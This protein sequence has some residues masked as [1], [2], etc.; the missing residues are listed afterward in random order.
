MSLITLPPDYG[1]YELNLNSLATASGS[2]NKTPPTLPFS[3]ESSLTNSFA[4]SQPS[5]PQAKKPLPFRQWLRTKVRITDATTASVIL[6]EWWP[7]HEQMTADLSE[8]RLI[9][10]KAR[11][12]SWSWFSAAWAVHGCMD[13]DH[14]GVLVISKGEDEAAEF[15]AKC[16]AVVENLPDDER[17]ALERSN[18]G[19]LAFAN[20]SWIRA[21]PATENAGRSYTGSLVIV[22]EAAFH[23]YAG[24]NY[25]A[26]KPS[27]D[28]GG[29]LI[30]ISTANG[31]GNWFHRMYL[32]ARDQANGFAAR[33]YPWSV[34]PGRDAGW[35]E[36]Q[37][38]EYAD[39][40][41]SIDQEY[42][43]N[44]D[45]AFILSGNP[46]FSI[47][48]I[49]QHRLRVR[50]PLPESMLPPELQ[51]LPG[52]SV[53]V[54]PQAGVP[55]VMGS[56]PAEGLATGDASDTKV[57]NAR[58]LEHVATLHGHWEPA[59]FTAYS[60]ALGLAYN[61]A[62][63]AWER[64]NHGHVMTRVADAE[65]HYP[66]MYWHQE[67][68]LTQ[69]QLMR[70]QGSQDVAHRLG[71]PTTSATK[72]GLIADLAS[73]IRTMALVSY[74]AE[75]WSECTTY[76]SEPNG[77]TNASEGNHDDRVMAMAIARMVA[78]TQPG[79]TSLVGQSPPSRSGGWTFG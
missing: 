50:P 62:Y 38:L 39:S 75:F 47:E 11:Q 66:R 33:F 73:V 79:A 35:Y 65:Y 74:E 61:Q 9:V 78:A 6:W 14:F 53:W 67:R 3:T 54:L 70:G 36:R 31:V 17:P 22:D 48:A 44:D 20:G 57:L 24:V 25:A 21:F 16:K 15:V 37:K 64:N 4:F 69:Q 7:V 28:A 56:D 12:V 59:V 58:T 8:R 71:F 45:D 2:K 19:L 1:H 51:R 34:R 63:W 55:Y 52:L 46:V 29:Q 42:P 30:I 26:Y 77:A 13:A 32:S 60:V 5:G 18:S 40:A 23:P 43:S 49:K 68:D 27:I 76:V 72:P 41:V 10:L